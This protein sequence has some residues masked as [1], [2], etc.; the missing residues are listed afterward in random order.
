MTRTIGVEQ[1][2]SV[3]ELASHNT[4]VWKAAVGPGSCLAQMPVRYSRMHPPARIRGATSRAE[5][6][7]CAVGG[8]AGGSVA[9]KTAAR[10]KRA[11][12]T[13]FRFHRCGLR[14]QR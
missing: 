3:G 2:Y 11:S 1:S 6:V 5:R 4:A 14:S 12:W 8:V 10:R 7:P 9:G 13:G